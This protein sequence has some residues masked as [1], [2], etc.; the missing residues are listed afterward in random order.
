MVSVPEPNALVLMVIGLAGVGFANA[1]RGKGN[2]MKK[3]C[4]PDQT[5]AGLHVAMA[6]A[7]RLKRVFNIDIATKRVRVNLPQFDTLSLKGQNPQRR[8]I[9]TKKSR[10]VAVS[11]D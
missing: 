1:R 9:M 7:Q 11:R 4:E 5:P 3:S 8:E 6:W 2:Q 10:Q